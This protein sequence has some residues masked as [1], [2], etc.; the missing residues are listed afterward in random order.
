MHFYRAYMHNN[1]K[2]QYMNA[3]LVVT[4]SEDIVAKTFSV[5]NINPVIELATGDNIYQVVFGEYADITQDILNR[6]PPPVRQAYASAKEIGV[7]H[8][9]LFIKKTEI[10]YTI[11][12][13]WK[14]TIG[15]DGN[16]KIVKV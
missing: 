14:I 1:Y 12:S 13:K 3:L 5:I 7:A 2:S 16:S 8:M 10:P 4:M 6:L 15:S 11:G 9:I